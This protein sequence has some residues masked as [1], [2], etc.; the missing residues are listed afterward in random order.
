[1]IR[2]I[3]RNDKDKFIAMVREFYRTD[4]VLQNIPE[5]NIIKTF[6]EL[7]SDSPYLHGY[8]CEYN[9]ETAG[10]VLLTLTYSN[11]AGGHVL[12][13]D[14]VYILP[15]YQSNGLGSEIFAF[16]ENKYKDNVARIRLDVEE[17]NDRAI[18][19]YQKLGFKVL[20]YLQMYK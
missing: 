11:E 9:G 4:A 6:D 14:E 5:E 16:I 10:Y 1:M 18:K 2:K 7:M 20:D 19:L 15:E 8:I 13:V 3:N 12:W 17:E